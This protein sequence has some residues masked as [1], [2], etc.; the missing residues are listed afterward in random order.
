MTA[1]YHQRYNVGVF[2]GMVLRAKRKE[3]KMIKVKVTEMTSGN[4][5]VKSFRTITR[6][7]KFRAFVNVDVRNVT[8]R[9][10]RRRL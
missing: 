8:G 4:S 6:A 5:F 2:R 10:L 9:N 3:T 7:R 1:I